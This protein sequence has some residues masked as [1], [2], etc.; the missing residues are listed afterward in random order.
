MCVCDVTEEQSDSPWFSFLVFPKGEAQAVGMRGG[1]SHAPE[2]RAECRQ[3]KARGPHCQRES[4]LPPVSLSA[5]KPMLIL[6]VP[7]LE[8]CFYPP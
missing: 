7:Y 5:I 8:V 2:R 3:T 6:K 1:R 4:L